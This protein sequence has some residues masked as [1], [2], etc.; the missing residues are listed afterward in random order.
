MM[1]KKIW[2]DGDTLSEVFDSVLKGAWNVP[3]IAYI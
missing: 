1:G 2:D 3:I